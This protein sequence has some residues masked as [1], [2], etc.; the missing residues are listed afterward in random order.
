MTTE[1]QEQLRYDATIGLFVR[2]FEHFVDAMRDFIFECFTKNG[3]ND[4]RLAEIMVAELTARPILD[5][6]PPIFQ[7]SYP[8]QNDAK[9]A[10]DNF[11]KPLYKLIEDRNLIIHGYHV[12][13]GAEGVGSYSMKKKKTQ[14]KGLR[15]DIGIIDVPLLNRYLR[16]LDSVNRTFVGMRQQLGSEKGIIRIIKTF[17]VDDPPEMSLAKIKESTFSSDT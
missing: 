8:S 2:D 9:K 1:D 5:F 4:K 7:V 17:R 6:I 15:V 3:L 12:G 14:Q 10:I 13:F 11:I 16:Y